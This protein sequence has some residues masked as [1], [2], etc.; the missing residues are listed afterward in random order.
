V[1]RSAGTRRR[2]APATD[3][4]GLRDPGSLV[5]PI[6]AAVGLLVIGALTFGLLTDRIPFLATSEPGGNGGNGGNGGPVGP[7]VTPA[8]SNVVV[9]P[10]DPRAEVPGTIV[11][12][13]Q[14]S[15]WL[16]EGTTVRQLT[17][18]GADSQPAWTSDGEWIYF[19]RTVVDRS[20]WPGEAGRPVYY[21]LTYPVLMRIHPDREEPEIVARGT[22]REGR[23]TW[24]YWIRQPTPNPVD[25]EQLAL[26]SD[27][28]DPSESNVVLQLYDVPGEAFTRAA[29]AKEIPPLGHQDPAWHPTGRILLYVMNDRDGRRGAPT[30]WR[31]DPARDRPAQL[32]GPGYLAPSYSPDGRYVAATKTT[33]FGTDVVI[34]DAATGGELLRVTSDGESWSPAWSPRG[35]AIAFFHIAGQIVDLRMATL[36]GSAPAFTV[37]DTIDLTVVSGLDGA[38]RPSWFIPADQLPAR[39]APSASPAASP[40]PSGS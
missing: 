31:Y 27:Q 14:G 20:L 38:S 36:G 25:P 23:Y 18:G 4:Y 12:A 26:L 1:S 19:I 34:L 10:K 28:P 24:F 29:G 8:P 3:P 9:V 32:T 5:G 16:Q 37:E 22:Y 21:T 40:S 33:P 39:P 15:I 2:T 17:T 30:I 13:K 11:Y 6:L 7:G 35:D